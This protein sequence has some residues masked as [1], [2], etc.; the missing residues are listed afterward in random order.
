MPEEMNLGEENQVIADPETNLGEENQ[1][2]T[3][4]EEKQ[5]KDI[6]HAFAEQRRARESAEKRAEEAERRLAEMEARSNAR[7]KVLE[8]L[9]GS[10]NA[11]I[12]ALAETMGID[13]ADI[14]A[15]LD[16]EEKS[17]EKDLEIQ[18]LSKELEDAKVAQ[19]MQEDL[20]EIQKIDPS[21]KSLNDLGEDFAAYV[22]AGLPP[23]KAYYA[24]KGE[25]IRNKVTPPKEIGKVDNKPAE[26][27]FFTEAEVDAL[28]EDQQKANAEK[29]MK[30]M[31]KW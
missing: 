24:I 28:T 13:S 5:S 26:K 31:E 16:F 17:A 8:R 20:A 12:D 2:I 30:S 19:M 15:T 9:G 6:D 14:M 3:D 1:V 4:P 27:D 18:R 10:Q 23:D 22:K 21:I 29:I 7:A 11:E 25:E